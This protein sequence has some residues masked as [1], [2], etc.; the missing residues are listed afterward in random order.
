MPKGM[1]R[2][3][4]KENNIICWLSYFSR[5]VE[6]YRLELLNPACVHALFRTVLPSSGEEITHFVAPVLFICSSVHYSVVYSPFSAS[7]EITEKLRKDN[8]QLYLVIFV[9]FPP[10]ICHWRKGWGSSSLGRYL[11]ALSQ[12]LCHQKGCSGSWIQR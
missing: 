6:A 1:W 10:G 11:R 4:I 9:S 3:N 2:L 7:A 8:N 5:M 12:N